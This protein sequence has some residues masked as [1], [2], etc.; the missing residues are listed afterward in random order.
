MI[1]KLKFSV[2]I[3]FAIMTWKKKQC[4]LSLKKIRD[5]YLVK[6]IQVHWILY[7]KCWKGVLICAEFAIAKNSYWNLFTFIQST[8]KA[9]HWCCYSEISDAIHSQHLTS[10]RRKCSLSFAVRKTKVNVIIFIRLHTSLSVAEN[11]ILLC[12]FMMSYL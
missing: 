2:L 4:V 9:W 11:W 1:I 6:L 5:Q 7:I 8:Q 10:E 12:E 3:N